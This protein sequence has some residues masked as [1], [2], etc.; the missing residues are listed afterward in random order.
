MFIL[1][2]TAT[3]LTINMEDL[4]SLNTKYWWSNCDGC[5]SYDKIKIC[6][7]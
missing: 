6:P 4:F 5:N 3:K 2:H 1:L 7:R